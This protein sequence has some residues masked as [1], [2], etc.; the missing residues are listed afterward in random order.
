VWTFFHS[1]GKQIK[2]K[3]RE[4]EPVKVV[5]KLETKAICLC[6]ILILENVSC[7][8]I[9]I[10]AESRRSIKRTCWLIFI[11]GHF[12][13]IDTGLENCVF[14]FPLR[15]LLM[16][17]P[18]RLSMVK[19]NWEGEG[20]AKSFNTWGFASPVDSINYGTELKSGLVPSALKIDDLLRS[21]VSMGAVWML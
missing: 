20:P 6:A 15:F 12:T 13:E 5:L 7:R 21:L 1:H 18:R 14:P 19:S 8:Y 10:W 2:A 4:E 17:I 3:S 11:F 9:Y 16:K